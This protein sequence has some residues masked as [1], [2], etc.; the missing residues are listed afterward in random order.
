MIPSTYEE[1]KNCLEVQCKISFT[2]E[3]LQERLRVL[4][5][6][7]H[8]ET[9]IFISKYGSDHYSKIINFYNKALS[10]T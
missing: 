10:L 1:W 8:H 6:R 5:D 9:K 3:F 7:N 2:P 4:K